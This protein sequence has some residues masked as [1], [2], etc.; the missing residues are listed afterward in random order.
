MRDLTSAEYRTVLSILSN[1]RATER[2]RIRLSRLPTSTYNVVRRRVFEEG[3]VSDVLVPNPGPCG[4]AGVELLLAR[5]SVSQRETL[6]PEW[7]KDPEC[8]LLWSGVHAVF[9][10]FFRKAPALAS[11]P[12]GAGPEEPGLLRVRAGPT[13]GS[14]PVY[15]DYSGLW[16]RFGGQPPPAAYPAGLDHSSRTA[17]A[18]TLAETHRWVRS[19]AHAD[20]APAR[21]TNLVSLGRRHPR[22]LDPEVVQA[23]TVLRQAKVPP[24]AGRRIGEVI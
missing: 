18:R 10:V 23:R 3:W 7:T 11:V 12:P 15:F 24:L 2:H 14:I 9:G 6:L 20:S 13:D 17:S 1:P 4:F 5:P 16:A 21:W 19:D 22:A 8:V